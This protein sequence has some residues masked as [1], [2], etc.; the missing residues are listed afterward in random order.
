MGEAAV[1]IVHWNG[2]GFT[3]R[4]IPLSLFGDSTYCFHKAAFAPVDLPAVANPAN[5]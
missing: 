3:D 5:P 1:H 2:T 4:A